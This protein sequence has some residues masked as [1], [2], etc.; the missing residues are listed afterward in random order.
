[1]HDQGDAHHRGHCQFVDR[2]RC[3][4]LDDGRTARR[5][6]CDPLRILSGRALDPFLVC[7]VRE[8][9]VKAALRPHLIQAAFLLS[10]FQPVQ[11]LGCRAVFLPA[12]QFQEKA[13]RVGLHQDKVSG[14]ACVAPLRGLY[15]L[16]DVLG[17]FRH[18]LAAHGREHLILI[19]DLR[20]YRRDVLR[21]LPHLVHVVHVVDALLV[22]SGQPV[23]YVLIADKILSHGFH[24]LPVAQRKLL[25]ILDTV[26]RDASCHEIDVA[27]DLLNRCPLLRR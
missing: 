9:P 13:L 3:A 23:L 12:S 26:R 19:S 24:G 1:M 11:Q 25:Q 4:V 14:L 8:E 21:K 17:H 2:A 27:D 10:A 7:L 22:Q 18:C 15:F 5:V 16:S 6:D 20:C